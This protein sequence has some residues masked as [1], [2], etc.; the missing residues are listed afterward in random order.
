M[1]KAGPL[2]S[3]VPTTSVIV[4]GVYNL[5]T[6]APQDKQAMAL[7]VDNEGNLL[8]NVAV[9]GGGAGSTVKIEDTSGNA[10]NSNG[11][12]A[13]N[14]AVVSGGGSNPS[15]GLT[16]SPAPTSAT[17]IGIIDISGNLQGASAANP[18]PVTFPGTIAVTQSTSPWVVSGTVTANQGG[19]PWSVT[20]PTPQHVIV[21]SGGGGG[22][23]YTDGSAQPSGSPPSLIGTAAMGYDGTDVWV[24]RVDPSTHYLQIDEKS[25]I[26]AVAQGSTTSGQSGTL[27]QG[28]VT[29]AA[30]VYSAGQTSPLSLLTSGNLRVAITG[31]TGV[32]FD[33][34]NPGTMEIDINRVGGAA[35]ATA[36]GGSLLVG[37]TGSVGSRLDAPGQNATAPPNE[38]IVGGQFNTTPTTL[39][40]T[41]VSPLQLDSVGSLRTVIEDAAGNIRGANVDASN[42][43]S[44][45]NTSWL[46]STAP[47]VGQKTSANSI[48]V[49]IA[50]DQSAVNV[51]ITGGTTSGTQYTDG[52]AV[53]A[54]SPP[55]LLGTAV[56]GFDGTD[57]WVLRLDSSTHYL[58]VDVKNAS[59]PV[60][61]STSPWVVNLTQLN[62]VVLASPTAWGTPASGSVIG[63][64]AEM[65]A[66]TIPLS[67]TLSGSPPVEALNVYVTN[68]TTI[69]GTVGVTGVYNVTEPAPADMGVTPLQ[70]DQAANLLVFP[71]VQFKVGQVWS[72]ATAQNTLQYPTG[73]TLPK[74]PSGSE[75]IIVQL[76][77]TST[78]TG[79]QV[80]FQGTRDNINW[81]TI[82]ASRV[83]TPG[84]FLPLPNPYTLIANTIQPFLLLPQGYIEVRMLLN[85]AITGSGTVSPYWSC[86]A[87]PP[88][89]VVL[90]GLTNNNVAPVATNLGVMPAVA[91]AAAQVWGEG[92]QVLL[93]EDLSGNLRVTLA[94]GGFPL[95]ATLAGSPPVEALNVYVVNTVAT[96]I[97]GTVAVT[98]ST[99]PWVVNATQWNSTS[100]GSPTAFGTAPSGNVIGV[101]AELFAG[102]FA[103]SAT[104]IGSPAVEALNVNIA[105]IEAG[106]TTIGKVDILGNSGAILDGVKTAATAPANGILTLG[107]FNSVLPSLTNG[108]SAGIQV[109]ASGQQLTDINYVLGAVHSKTNPLFVAITDGTNVISNAVSAWG[110]A[111][112]GTKVQGV[113]AELF[114]GNFPLTVTLAGSPPVEALNVN[115]VGGS[116]GNAAAS[117]TGSAVPTSAD[118]QG[119]N[120]GGT[121]RGSTGVNPSGTVY[122]TQIDLASVAGTTILTGGIAG[123][124]GVGGL[125]ANTVTAVGNPVLI[126]GVNP[127]NGAVA[128]VS[129]TNT[130][131]LATGV[132]IGGSDSLTNVLTMMITDASGDNGPL[133]S[134]PFLFNG[135]TWDRQRSSGIGNNVAQTGI[136]AAVGYGIYNTTIPANT[137]GNAGQIQIDSTGSQ[138]VNLE[139]NKA[140]Y[141]A[142]ASFTP[143]TVLSPPTAGDVSVMPGSATKTIRITRVEVS[144]ST[145]GTATIDAVQLVKRSVA[146]TL[147]TPT[148]MPVVPHDS[149]FAAASAVP[150]S[151]SGSTGPALGAAVGTVRGVQFSDASSALP[152]AN[153]W[154]FTFGDGRAGAGCIVLRGTAQQL[155]VN[156]SATVSAQIV[157][158]SYEW[159]EE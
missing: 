49:V 57:A 95:T 1:S 7:Q 119:V 97:S 72:S 157:A 11:A 37:I 115:I 22:T 6:P 47:T 62:S 112:T 85:I 129:C 29:A 34:S 43:L 82:P 14:V 92:N 77:Q 131:I 120:V 69:S 51:N 159:T 8:V 121:L 93:S 73:T 10:L 128:T 32:S 123:S 90:G 38:I 117:L 25:S 65:F 138:Y 81:T 42:R 86:I 147:G 132:R 30:P 61:Q 100:L 109:D 60:T 56:M 45:D 68:P 87:N 40:T 98:Q 155:C 26:L 79:G 50:S 153:T 59:I 46:G 142:F 140:T 125:A 33:L 101:N 67:A 39:T 76:D 114:A 103:L 64:N 154:I 71:G 104:L 27:M 24:L 28:A 12:G 106:T 124:Q 23:Q 41:H 53:P 151:Y 143:P 70:Q 144:L 158:V 3:S 18:V 4:G 130:G 84:T 110:T 135:T 134:M 15:V 55:V 118:Y 133:A 126:A 149:N 48:P 36:A 113:N 35:V 107:V 91:N 19:A 89:D 94:A 78:I 17:E 139:G 21:D 145:S 5:V 122:A 75:A 63:V 2:N 148:N 111:P 74:A 88:V 99:S 108:Q 52:Q 31:S 102:T 150:K 20:F 9:G 141:S 152:G 136:L 137:P 105:G 44:I 80:T 16:G 54:G 96:T 146:D 66:G 83:L 58:Q 127:L 116:S 156:I 13:L